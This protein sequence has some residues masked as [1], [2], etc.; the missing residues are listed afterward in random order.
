MIPIPVI[1]STTYFHPHALDIVQAVNDALNITSMA[2]L[3]ACWIMLIDSAVDVVISRVTIGEPVE[4]KRVEG[5]SPV[6]RG[7]CVFISFW[8]RVV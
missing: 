4:E 5:K 6:V 3:V 1:S 2:Q 8:R 7:R